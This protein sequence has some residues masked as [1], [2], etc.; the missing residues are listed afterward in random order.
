MNAGELIDLTRTLAGMPDVPP[1]HI[2]TLLNTVNDEVSRDLRL[3]IGTV[4]FRGITLVSQLQIPS[5]GREEGMLAL[6]RLTVDEDDAVTGSTK[7]P[8]W[9]FQQASEYEP[10]W[11]I[12]VAAEAARFVV[13]DPAQ[14]YNNPTP[15][16]PPSAEY[17]HDYRMV[18]MVRPC[19]MENFPDLPLD[20][21]H[22]SFHDILAYR[23]AYLL[24]RDDRLGREHELKIRRARAA[25]VQ[26]APVIQNPLWWGT[27]AAR[28]G[29]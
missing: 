24:T 8:L 13:Y 26:T 1:A 9:T 29:R 16:P 3:P 22:A 5:D 2:L 6:Y 27:G 19:P 25:T 12:E 20:G 17:P 23:A 15:V 11:T 21:K 10:Q 7:L 4:D 14:L 28:G 18:Y